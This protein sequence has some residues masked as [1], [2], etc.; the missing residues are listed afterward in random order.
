MQSSVF[1]DDCSDCVFVVSS[2]QVRV[3]NAIRC[4]FYLFVRSN[5][6]IE[7]SSALRF[8]PYRQYHRELDGERNVPKDDDEKENRWRLVED[9]N[10]RRS[11]PSPNW[12]PL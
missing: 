2:Q 10:W 4:D 6:I 11:G 12:S 5:P 8:A 3:H 9:F 1:L 7:D